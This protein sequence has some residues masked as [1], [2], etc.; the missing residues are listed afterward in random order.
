MYK[1]VF[2]GDEAIMIFSQVS[3]VLWCSRTRKLGLFIGLWLANH[4]GFIKYRVD[5]HLMSS[6]KELF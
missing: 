2:N 3:I 6:V 1:F 4:D 5:L